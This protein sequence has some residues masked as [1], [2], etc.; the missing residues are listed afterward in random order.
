M[1]WNHQQGERGDQ[2]KT[3]MKECHQEGE[4]VSG[5]GAGGGQQGTMRV[6]EGSSR[7]DVWKMT[8]E[9]KD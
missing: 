6:S 4:E 1:V 8:V 3:M 2:V 9:K 5:G 7:F